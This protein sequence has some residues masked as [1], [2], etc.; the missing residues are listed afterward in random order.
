MH[1]HSSVISCGPEAYLLCFLYLSRTTMMAPH[2]L[3][4]ITLCFITGVRIVQ[5]KPPTEPPL[6]HGHPF[7]AIWNA[8]ITQCRKYEIPVDL[9][10]FQA[11]T[12]PS[13]VPDQ[14]LIIFY[15]HRLGLYPKIDTETGKSYEGGI[16][17]NGNLTAHLHKARSQIPHN[18]TEDSPG[19][20]VIDWES[21][22]PLWARNWGTKKIY[23]NKSIEHAQKIN[24]SLSPQEISKLAKQQFEEAGR[25]F[26]EKTISLGTTER[27]GRNWGF[28]LFPDCYNY[29]WEEP[30]YTGRCSEKTKQ[31]NDQL[32][33]L[34]ESSTGFFPSVYIAESLRNS[35]YAKLYVRNRVQE[36]LRVAELPKHPHTAPVYVYSRPLFRQQTEIYLGQ[37]KQLKSVFM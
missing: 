28:Y 13:P 30:G 32:L 16:P 26:M 10:S 9:A 15:E 11:V 14:F 6:I 21:W 1:N 2:I 24:A 18:L 17:Q 33:W 22:R 27:P 3:S 4:S 7:V 25:N 12:T 37:V 29:G 8:P 31:Q 36:A 19:L 23:R 20:A 35:P 34:W 5:A